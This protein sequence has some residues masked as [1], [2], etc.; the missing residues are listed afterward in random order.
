MPPYVWR[1]TDTHDCEILGV[2]G[3]LFMATGIIFIDNLMFKT[4]NDAVKHITAEHFLK[5]SLDQCWWYGG[6]SHGS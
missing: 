4:S 1:D 6:A 3:K 2:K 5:T